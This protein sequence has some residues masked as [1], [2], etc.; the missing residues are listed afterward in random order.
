MKSLKISFPSVKSPVF[1]GVFIWGAY[2]LYALSTPG[3]G[4]SIEQYLSIMLTCF[5]LDTLFFYLRSGECRL[6]LSG[7]I[8][9]F[10]LFFLVDTT[11]IGI[12]I[13]VAALTMTTKHLFTYRERHIFNPTNLALLIVC[14]GFSDIATF[15]SMRWGGEL[16]W[17]IIFISLGALITIYANRWVVAVTYAASFTLFA[18][19]K[20]LIFPAAFDFL[21]IPLMGPGLQ[22]FTFFMITDPQTSPPKK[23]QQFVFAILIAALDSTFRFMQNRYAPLLSLSIICL[24]F[25]LYEVYKNLKNETMFLRTKNV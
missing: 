25:T 6:T 16:F 1:F 10:A 9:G 17:S 2:S 8:S 24:A 19:A 7:L 12:G 13:L 5:I 4:R 21:M 14:Y 18:Y 15:H 20:S 11:Y 22:L 23:N 3:F